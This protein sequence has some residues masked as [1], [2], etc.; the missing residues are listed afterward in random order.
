MKDLIMMKKEVR[1]RFAPSPSGQIHLGNLRSAIF[2]YIFAKKYNGKFILRIEDTDASRTVESEIARI[3]QMLE[4]FGINVDEGPMTGGQFGPYQQSLRNDLYVEVLNL[5][6]QE[7]KIYKCFCSKEELES[8]RLEQ[9]KNNIAPRYSRKCL[10]LS[11]DK[12]LKK[13]EFG[14]PFVWRFR[15]NEHQVIKFNDLCKGEMIFSMANFSDFTI[16]R[17]DGSFTFI[18]VNF[19]DDW[20]MGI[21]HVIRG[22]D[23]LSNTPLQIAL[24]QTMMVTPPTFGHLPMILNSDGEKL[25]KRNKHSSLESLLSDGFVPPAIC[26]YLVRFGNWSD[27]K[28][29]SLKTIVSEFDPDQLKSS[30]NTRYDEAQLCWLNEHWIGELSGKELLS[31]AEKIFPEWFCQCSSNSNL[32]FMLDQLKTEVKNLLDLTILI[33][34]LLDQS[35]S[36][37]SIEELRA[38]LTGHEKSAQELFKFLCQQLETTDLSL[39]TLLSEAK[40]INGQMPTKIIFQSVRLIGTGKAHGISIDKLGAAIPRDVLIKKLNIALNSL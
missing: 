13:T 14:T 33:K 35:I 25:S 26:D 23:H 19:V 15:L 37:E 40:K 6:A 8:A 5:L 32:E 17:S 27:Q 22:D 11:S 3:S 38:L 29:K 10:G 1:T 28:P 12:V 30:A 7:G 18:F 2:S 20:K 24:Y 9:I 21:S 36:S 39:N 34:A 16:T 31:M 4:F